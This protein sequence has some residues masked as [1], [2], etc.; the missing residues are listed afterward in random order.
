[1]VVQ[2]EVWV[3]LVVVVVTAAVATAV[4]VGTEAVVMAA[5]TVKGAVVDTNRSQRHSPNSQTFINQS[6]AKSLLIL[7]FTSLFGRRCISILLNTT[8]H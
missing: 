6:L 5:V 7:Q 1:V 4:A 3:H 2:V 8:Y